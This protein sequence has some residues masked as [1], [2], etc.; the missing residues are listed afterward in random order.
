MSVHPPS[1]AETLLE[2]GPTAFSGVPLSPPRRGVFFRAWCAFS[3]CGCRA[4]STFDFSPHRDV[5]PELRNVVQEL[6]EQRTQIW[7]RQAAKGP[8]V[9]PCCAWKFSSVVLY[10]S[11][12]EV[13]FDD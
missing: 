7:T 13:V 3:L 8:F 9:L 2:I 6:E 10:I 12:V 5:E 4:Q 1:F 11:V